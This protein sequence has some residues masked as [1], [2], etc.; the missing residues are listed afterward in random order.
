MMKHYIKI[1]TLALTTLH[2]GCSDKIK[3]NSKGISRQD[4]TAEKTAFEDKINPKEYVK[5]YNGDNNKL[6]VFVGQ[7]IS[8]DELPVEENA[9]D[10]GFKAKYI[11]I[12]KVYGNFSQDTIEFVAFDHHG[13]P[14]FSKFDHVLLFVS[15]DSG[16]Y[17]HQKYQYYY[18]YKTRDGK[19][20]GTY[21]FGEYGHEYNKKTS[22]QPVKI[23]FA[24]EVAYPASYIDHN[25]KSV[26]ID[27]PKPYFKIVGNKAVAVYGNYVE[28]L[29]LLKRDG[30][31]TARGIFTDGKLNE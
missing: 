29:F 28:E 9:M 8:V 23:D 2:I 16:T 5:N 13:I 31:L 15:A 12:Q 30:V 17:Y 11:V 26:M 24:Q 27:Y 10:F 19:W 21:A 6:F 7:K 20:A 18:V 22:I 4:T 14:P 25:G 1:M 3:S